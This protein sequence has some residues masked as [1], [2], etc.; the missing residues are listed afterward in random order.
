MW[1][2]CGFPNDTYE[3]HPRRAIRRGKSCRA[4]IQCVPYD[5]FSALDVE[6]LVHDL[7]DGL[8]VVGDVGVTVDGVLDAG[9]ME[10]VEALQKLVDVHLAQVILGDGECLRS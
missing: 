6:I 5:I 10:P 9:D 3:K 7:L 4:R 1:D 8:V 2:F